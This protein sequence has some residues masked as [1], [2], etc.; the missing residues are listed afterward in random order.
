MWIKGKKGNLLPEQI[1]MIVL[2]LV[3]IGILILFITIRTGDAH[4]MEESYAKKIALILDS[5]KPGMV[6]HLNMEDAISKAEKNLGKDRIGS[7]V[8]ITGNIVTVKLREQGGYSYS[9]FNNFT[10]N[11]YIDTTNNKEFV[12]LIEDIK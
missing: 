3:F 6:I 2:N 10:V 8:S 12:F 11:S 9:F 1:V 5:A 4:A 7:I